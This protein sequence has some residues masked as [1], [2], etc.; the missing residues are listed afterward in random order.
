[1]ETYNTPAWIDGAA[2]RFSNAFKGKTQ[3]QALYAQDAWR[4]LP[5][6]KFVYGVRYEDWQANDGLQA[7]GAAALPYP[8]AEAHHFSPKA[9]LSFDVTDTLTLRASVGRAYRFPTVSELFQG[10]INGSSI[11]NNNPNLQPEDDLSKEL[12]AE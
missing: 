5:R 10:Q 4:F 3:T 9:S 6:W 12:T 2:G 8:N 11:F 1:N 7:V